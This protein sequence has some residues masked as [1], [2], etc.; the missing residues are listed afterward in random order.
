MWNSKKQ[1]ILEQMKSPDFI[2]QLDNTKK[3]VLQ[4]T[5]KRKGNADAYNAT[6]L[7]R[8]NMWNMNE[9]VV[10]VNNNSTNTT[11]TTNPVNTQPINTT[12]MTKGDNTPR[13]AVTEIIGNNYGGD[14]NAYYRDL[15]KAGYRGK[16]DIGQMQTF[17]SAIKPEDVDNYMKSVKPNNK[18]I[19]I[20]KD[21]Y[22][23]KYGKIDM[24][25]MSPED[26]I[27]AYRDYKWDYRAPVVGETQSP[28]T[29]K[30][31]VKPT[32]TPIKFPS[33]ITGEA[34]KTK[35]SFN[36][37]QFFP[38]GV[39]VVGGEEAAARFEL[40]NTQAPFRRMSAQPQI[41]EINRN[42]RAGL[43]LL[44]N[45]PTDVS[46]IANLLAQANSQGQQA[47]GNVNMQNA[48]HQMNVDQFNSQLDRQRAIAQMQ[49]DV[50]FTENIAKRKGLM[51]TEANMNKAAFNQSGMNMFTELRD[52]NYADKIY[53]PDAWANHQFNFDPNKFELVP[54]KD[55]KDKKAKYGGKIK[56]KLTKKSSK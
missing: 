31:K 50:R 47:I 51:Q 9:N 29:P 26:R 27:E 1:S 42:T 34:D 10:S 54:K 32:D 35:G 30:E 38:M 7:P 8:I 40:P 41:N 11:P 44:G 5:W 24:S 23:S 14:Q 3:E 20:W 52:K 45:T 36:M 15:R 37:P 43:S 2:T 6:S 46:N 25:K 17:H 48:Q 21:K 22:A 19:Q 55:D 39:P 53:S 18:A 16:N 12:N 33:K 28:F 4:D 49:E 56:S 13:L